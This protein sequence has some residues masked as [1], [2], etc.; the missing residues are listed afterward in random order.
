MPS[1]APTQGNTSP[2]SD[3]III[4]NREFR[5]DVIPHGDTYLILAPE[6]ARFLGFRDVSRFMDN[7]FEE[8]KGYLTVWGKQVRFVTERG[9]HKS[10]NQ[11]QTARIKDPVLRERADRFIAWVYG[12]ASREINRVMSNRPQPPVSTHE[13]APEPVVEANVVEIS[14]AREPQEA[15]AGSDLV[16][17]S[18]GDEEVRIVQINNEPWW[19]APDVARVLEYRDSHAI[20]RSVDE[21]DK[22]THVVW[23]PGGNQRVVVISEAGLYSAIVRANSDRAKPFRRWVTHEV[24]PEIRKTGGY[25]AP[26]TTG[27]ELTEDEIVHQALGI[28][29]RK[30]EEL[31]SKVQ[32]L[33]P[34]AEFYSDLMDASGTYDFAATARFLGLGRNIMMRELRRLR[35][36]QSDNLP[37]RQYD[38]HFKVIPTVFQHPNTGEDMVS[39]KTTVLPSGVEF[40]RKK[41]TD[42]GVL[43]VAL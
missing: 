24:L 1:I 7:V 19:V 25:N 18:Y 38:R 2:A 43:E 6:V 4:Q 27:H 37:Y 3:P 31:E 39:Y 16:P 28:L 35:V 5:L 30:T 29:N 26:A 13:P 34:K 33:E 10:L 41:L 17:F 9:F 8:D 36:L 15:P 23:T 20:T 22:G 42:A 32:E 21:E 40:L 11:R 14:K 12:E